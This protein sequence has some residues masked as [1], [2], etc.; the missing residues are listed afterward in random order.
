MLTLAVYKER[1]QSGKGEHP[2]TELRARTRN[3]LN[4]VNVKLAEDQ[5][6]N[7]KNKADTTAADPIWT[8]TLSGCIADNYNTIRLRHGL[9]RCEITTLTN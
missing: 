2:H 9:G 7:A 5:R 4:F 8:P 6:K 1:M 3:G